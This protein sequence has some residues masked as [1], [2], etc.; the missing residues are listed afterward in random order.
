VNEGPTIAPPQGSP[1]LAS[2]QALRAV[3]GWMVVGTHYCGTFSVA[4]PSWIQRAFLTHGAIGV[5]I[6]FVI[7]GLVMGLTASAPDTRPR[8]FAARRLARIVPA[9]WFYTLVA[10]LLI[11]QAPAVMWNW[12]YSDELLVKSMLF[13]PVQN[14]AVGGL[15]PVLTVGWT[16]NLEMLFYLIVAAA[17]FVRG[18]LRWL[19]IATAMMAVQLVSSYHDTIIYEFLMGIVAA[20][21]WKAG[22]LRGPSWQFIGLAIVAIVCLAL[23]DSAAARALELGVP[24]FLLVCACLGLEPYFTRARWVVHLGNHSYSV[25]LLHTLV[26]AVA[27]DIHRAHRGHVVLISVCALAAIALLGAASY[28]FLERPAGRFVLRWLLPRRATTLSAAP[29]SSAA[30]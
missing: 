14:D 12:G 15:Y 26:I 30:A 22:V 8:D 6:F 16:L 10:A 25:Y 7:S 4:S 3:A 18:P 17:L 24:S 11:T 2:I 27:Y 28:H 23:T 5:D 29:A 21:L 1:I 20:H 13:V 9:Y 19:W